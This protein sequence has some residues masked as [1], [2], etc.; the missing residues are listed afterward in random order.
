MSNE[1]EESY[2][3]FSARKRLILFKWSILTTL[4]N[5]ATKYRMDLWLSPIY[6]TRDKIPVEYYVQR[7][8]S[9]FLML[10]FCSFQEKS[11]RKS[12]EQNDCCVVGNSYNS[13]NC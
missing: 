1:S 10:Q 6:R 11:N 4:G 9:T 12:I 7:L 2:F 13:F 3:D 5:R 8:L